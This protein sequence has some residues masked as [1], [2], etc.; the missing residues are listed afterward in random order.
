M[1]SPEMEASTVV[2]SLVLAVTY[3]GS[4]QGV[5]SLALLY[6]WWVDPQ[7][8]RR[9]ALLLG[10]SWLINQGLK[11]LF[12]LP[13][14]FQVDGG[15]ASPA[16]AATAY[17]HGFP[18]G[19]AQGTSTFWFYLAFL[20]GR[21]G[22]YVLAGVM[23][24]AVGLSR[25]FLGVHYVMDVVAGVGVGVVLAWLGVR[26]PR[27]GPA[28]WWMGP[29]VCLAVFP[30]VLL[31]VRY[32]EAAGLV[33]GVF[34]ARG[35]HRVPE[36]RWGRLGVAVGGLALLWGSYYL[37]SPVMGALPALPVA[38]GEIPAET[39]GRYVRAVLLSWLAFGLWPGWVLGCESS[40]PSADP[41]ARGCSE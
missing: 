9:L 8:G 14:P 38:G 22:L 37:L 40:G 7:G 17:G 27:V 33:V 29:G 25:V 36:G 16:A 28:P 34:L 26:A 4:G 21:S 19:H 31:G 30:A 18:S 1:I 2:D 20:H 10:V 6:T 15:L 23:V 24:L 12:G 3:L 11:D 41:G 32:A 13:R 39:W 35:D 5:I